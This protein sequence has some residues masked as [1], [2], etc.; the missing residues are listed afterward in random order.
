MSSDFQILL[1]MNKTWSI[2]THFLLISYLLRNIKV[3]ARFIQ[4]CLKFLN[5]A[6]FLD[7]AAIPFNK[8]VSVPPK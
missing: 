4:S 8:A 3:K 7:I 1:I 2:Y 6:A 5:Y